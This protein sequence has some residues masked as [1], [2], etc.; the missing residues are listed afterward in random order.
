MKIDN[1]FAAYAYER[2]R[3]EIVR[4]TCEDVVRTSPGDTDVTAPGHS[5]SES[6]L[7]GAGIQSL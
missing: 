5:A 6:L 4:L 7:T 1:K 2:P 3:M